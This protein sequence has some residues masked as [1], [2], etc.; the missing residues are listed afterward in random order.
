MTWPNYFAR[1]WQHWTATKTT[2]FSLEREDQELLIFG[3]VYSFIQLT[4]S[5]Q[6]EYTGLILKYVFTE[7]SN[8]ELSVPGNLLDSHIA[9]LKSAASDSLSILKMRQYIALV[10]QNKVKA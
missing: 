6:V 3:N 5:S 2:C 7:S 8:L 9:Q 10:K 1:S 4:L